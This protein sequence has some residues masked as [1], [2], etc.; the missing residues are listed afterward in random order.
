MKFVNKTKNTIYLA[1]IDMY[2]PYA[3]NE[4]QYISSDNILKSEGFQKLAILGEIEII[5]VNNSR[6]ENNLLRLG[7][8]MSKLKLKTTDSKKF[9]AKNENKNPKQVVIKGHFLEGG[10]YA[11]VNRNLALGLKDLDI[12]VKVNIVGSANVNEAYRNDV[13]RVLQLQ[14][15][16]HRDAIK[17]DSIVPSMSEVTSG[18]NN[19]L[20]TTIE[21][22][23]IPKQFID[24][25]QMYNEIWVT[26]DFC[27]EIL[28]EHLP[29][30]AISVIPD[31]IDTNHYTSEG[32]EF[33][34]QPK[35]NPFVFL[36]VFGWSY[37]K[38]YDVLLKS[39]LKAFTGDDPVSLLIVSKFQNSPDR[40][41]FIKKYID[42]QIK[43]HGG[44]NPPNIVRCSKHIPESQ[45][46]S[47]YRACDAFCLPSRGEGFGLI[48]CESSLCGLPVIGTNCSGQSMFLKE[49]NSYLIEIDR[50]E[51]MQPGM[52]HV[53]YWDNQK[54]PSLTSK[55]VI[56]QT[57][58]HMR[59]VFNNYDEARD[60]N[61]KLQSFIRNNYSISNVSNLVK[62]RL[63]YLWSKS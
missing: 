15:T 24:I 12:D 46:P 29:N 27:A 37:R 59:Y 53:H 33:E 3:E 36:S 28:S 39:Y 56:D 38:G 26:S 50:L 34:F 18:R 49:D 32:E 41:D 22:Y 45:M 44:S 40:S 7:K 35:L 63:D 61:R 1:D 25:A 11:K 58:D 43:E 17:V 21:S 20:Y 6:I 2:I 51:E 60:K 54:F 52:M 55:S 5:E 31:P 13:K 19:V 47:L 8:S 30:K 16:V 4:I 57:V 14:G 62:D 9:E 48:Y 10:G 23:T 42:E